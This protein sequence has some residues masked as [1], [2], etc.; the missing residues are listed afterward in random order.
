M[1]S[2]TQTQVQ[3]EMRG[4][5]ERLQ[6]LRDAGVSMNPD[7][8]GLHKP[9]LVRTSQAG[10]FVGLLAA[11]TQHG[12]VLLNSRRLWS[13][14]TKR[15]ISLTCLAQFGIQESGSRVTAPAPH[16]WLRPIEVIQLSDEIF[17]QIM[18]LPIAEA[19]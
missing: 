17:T 3:V 18:T 6:A 1:T 15:G 16:Q 5:P 4:T 10:V 19:Q 14:S 9:T 11:H 13:W 2:K 12:A 7:E 8:Y